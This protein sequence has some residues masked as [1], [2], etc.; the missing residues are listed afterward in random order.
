MHDGARSLSRPRRDRRGGRP[1][2]RYGFLYKGL[3]PFL[4]T[5]LDITVQSATVCAGQTTNHN[6]EILERTDRNFQRRSALG[7]RQT[8]IQG[9]DFVGGRI[10]KPWYST[11]GIA[12]GPPARACCQLRRGRPREPLGEWEWVRPSFGERGREA[13]HAC[14]AGK[15]SRYHPI[16]HFLGCVGGLEVGYASRCRRANE[17]EWRVH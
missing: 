3:E 6:D 13:S 8:I 14:V 5:T 16:G 2:T 11:N 4:E 7:R 15:I 9:R 10:D 1:R 17:E 12:A